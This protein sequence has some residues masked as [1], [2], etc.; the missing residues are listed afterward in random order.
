[1]KKTVIISLAV[2][3]V[4]LLLTPTTYV[5]VSVSV[6]SA[7]T[8]VVGAIESDTTWTAANSPYI[9]TSSVLVSSGVT[10]IIEPGVIV[11]FDSAQ[12]I[13]IDGQLIAR[14]NATAPIIFTSNQ[15]SPA[16]G[17]WINILFT[18]TSVDATYN[19]GGNYVSG[20]IMQYCTMEYGGGG[21]HT[22]ILKITSS[23]PFIDHCI[24]TNSAYGGI[25]VD[26]GSPKISNCNFSDNLGGYS[27]GIYT[28]DS[29]V[30][31]SNCNIS[32][33]SAG[34]EGVGGGIY[35]YDSTM[36]ISNC[37]ISNNSAGGDGG[38][39][40]TYDST[41]TISNCNISNNSAGG[42]GGGIYTYDSTV[43]ISNCNI[44]NNSAGGDGGG[45]YMSS[46]SPKISNCNISNNLAT[47]GGG[48]LVYGYPTINCNNIYSNT[49][50]DV[51]NANSQGSPHVDATY[52]WWGT[53]VET[54]IQFNIYDWN[55]AD[56]LGIVDYHPYLTSVSSSET[57]IPQTPT[58]TATPTPTAISNGS[59][60]SGSVGVN[61]ANVQTND[62]KIEIYFPAGAFATTTQ[63]VITSNTSCHGNT[64]AF[65]VGN[66]CFTITPDGELGALATIC[67]NLS[68]YDFSIVENGSD[69]KLGYWANDSWNVASNVTII[70][71]TICGETS[72]LSDWAV[73]GAAVNGTPTPTSTPSVSPIPTTTA[74]PTSTPTPTNTPSQIDKSGTNWALIGGIAGGV[75]LLLAI[76]IA[77][78]I[79]SRGGKS[80][81]RNRKSKRRSGNKAEEIHK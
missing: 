68:P 7:S 61:G 46:G 53:A 51:F 52:N 58:L 69:I 13:Q 72:H 37:N 77:I 44:S 29:T 81:K 32:N 17:D 40:Y 36:T 4:A 80:A 73:L 65:V 20:S 39:I 38:G 16:S 28:Y 78:T 79:K 24:V 60:G 6:V 57:C 5:L 63:V 19:V 42:D 50:L 55:D 33:N 14:G 1:M 45:I 71:T 43:T 34:G 67:V 47:R 74:Q 49:P 15:S 8:N 22:P 56:I 70:G 59:T 23:S 25:Y 41:M 35:T 30:T 11:K 64:T 62:G 54:T 76:I 21:T 12:E 75:I 18:D 2:I 31:I 66:T 26:R 9:L 48:L 10:L 3:L 27:G